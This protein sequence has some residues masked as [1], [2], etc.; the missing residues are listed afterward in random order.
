MRVLRQRLKNQKFASE[1]SV[2]CFEALNEVQ[3]EVV[4]VPMEFRASSN[5]KSEKKAGDRVLRADTPVVYTSLQLLVKTVMS[6]LELYQLLQPQMFSDGKVCH[7]LM[8]LLNV[9]DQL[10]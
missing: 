9:V 3:Y 5:C 10:I 6:K 1:K 7:N 4:E 2:R 8:Q